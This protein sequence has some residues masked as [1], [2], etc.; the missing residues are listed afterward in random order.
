MGTPASII[1]PKFR[2]SMTT[3]SAPT[4][5]ASPG[6][7]ISRRLPTPSSRIPDGSGR[8]PRRR[9]SAV[10]AAR[11]AASNSP[12]RSLPSRFLPCHR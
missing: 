7:A 1:T 3:S 10:T 9:N 6:M 4:L 5:G 11:S 2:V 12:R 8:I